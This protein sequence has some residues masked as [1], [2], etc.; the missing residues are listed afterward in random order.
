M[1]PIVKVAAEII[2][3]VRK[4][5]KANKRHV[6]HEEIKQKQLNFGSEMVEKAEPKYISKSVLKNGKWLKQMELKRL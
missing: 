3:T 2:I 6:Q 5:W 1:M 4:A